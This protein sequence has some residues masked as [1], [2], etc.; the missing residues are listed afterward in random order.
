MFIQTP[1]APDAHVRASLRG[2]PSISDH[3]AIREEGRPRRAALTCLL[4]EQH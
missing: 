2:H 1:Q 4:N 3:A